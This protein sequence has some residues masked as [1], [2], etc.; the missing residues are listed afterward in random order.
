MET[1]KETAVLLKELKAFLK[2]GNAHKTFEEAIKD[3]P[4]N[5][6]G[7]EVKNMPY[8]IWQLVYHIWLTQWDILEFSRD[9]SHQSPEWPKGYWPEN[10]EPKPG[11]WED[12]LTKIENDK[13]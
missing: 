2:G 13:K 1:S 10:K 9:A 4:E 3:L 8:T 5:L 12:T 11:E 6:R 7:A